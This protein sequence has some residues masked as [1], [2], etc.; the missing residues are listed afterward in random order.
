MLI[1]DHKSNKLQP[2]KDGLAIITYPIHLIAEI[3]ANFAGWIGETFS[4]HTTL[5]SD[6]AQLRQQNR[7]LKGMMLRFESLE[8][9][10]NQLR[11]QLGASLRVGER[12]T[13]AELTN[14]DLSPYRQQVWINKGSNAGVHI[15]QAVVD[16]HAIMG[17]VTQ[18][19]PFRA[20]V[21]L[22]TDSLHS[23]PVQILRTGLRTIA[24]GSGRIDKLELPYL[25]DNADIHV[26]DLLVTSGLGEHF[27]ADYPV[28]RITAIDLDPASRIRTVI[29]TPLAKLAQ[30]K[31]VML[32]W[33]AE[34]IFAEE[35]NEETTAST[36]TAESNDDD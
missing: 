30:D 11:E 10:N 29:A 5:L 26:G 14:V 25:P 4:S 7:Q 15:G 16:A 20:T 34:Q 12:V 17:Q 1:A 28:A 31:N 3:P 13:L 36:S 27:P 32:V 35:E 8:E 2:L 22:I 6:N 21:L 9:E 23:I 18:V 24:H 19:T 33:Q